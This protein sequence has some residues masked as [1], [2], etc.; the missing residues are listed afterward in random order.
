MTHVSPRIGSGRDDRFP[1]TE[2]LFDETT[3]P[4]FQSQPD[5]WRYHGYVG[6]Y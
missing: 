2:E 4:G 3:I 5:F 1:S 6:Y